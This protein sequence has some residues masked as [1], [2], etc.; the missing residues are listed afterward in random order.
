MT[1][2][3][4]SQALPVIASNEGIWEGW[5]RY[6]DAFT[7]KLVDEHK[8]RLHC[9]IIRE[10][11]GTERYHQ[12]NYYYWDDGRTDIRDFPA[13]FRDGRLRWNNDLIEG[14]CTEMDMDE[15]NRSSCLYWERK[16]E[17]G[18][19][20]YEMIQVND[21]RTHRART[22]QWFKDGVCYQ[23]TL[24]DERFVT[25]DWQNWTDNSAPSGKL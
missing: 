24:I 23:R 11:D 4:L 21:A 1:E 22:W 13:D 18:L 20:L 9:R 5:Y 12:T 10:A 19:E 7:G 16:N 25:R 6:Y 14:W 2:L 17:P 8:S 3:T 15:F